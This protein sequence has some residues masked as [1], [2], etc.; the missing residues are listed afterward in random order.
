LADAASAT[1]RIL[2]FKRKTKGAA[3]ESMKVDTASL[4]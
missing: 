4:V 1:A 3:L 2:N